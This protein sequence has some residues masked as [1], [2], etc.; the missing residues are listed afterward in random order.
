[1]LNTDTA[2]FGI[3]SSDFCAKSEIEPTKNAAVTIDF[4]RNGW[5]AKLFD[6][7]ESKVR[8]FYFCSSDSLIYMALSNKAV[9]WMSE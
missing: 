1:M 5:C 7:P 3:S 4:M 6:W 8:I 9:F 2:S